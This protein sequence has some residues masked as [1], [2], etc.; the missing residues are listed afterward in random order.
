MHTDVTG[1]GAM[2][3]IILERI[4]ELIRVRQVIHRN[5]IETTMGLG[6]SGYGPAHAAKTI[7]GNLR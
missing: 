6:D 1:E 2:I 4:G 7:D 5:H 3:T